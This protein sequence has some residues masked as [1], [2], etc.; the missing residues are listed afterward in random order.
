MY[1]FF[2]TKRYCYFSYFSENI[3]CGY[4]IEVPCCRGASNKYLQCTFSWR[5]KEHIYLATPLN[6]YLENMRNVPV[7]SSYF[8][9]KTYV[10]HMHKKCLGKR[11][12]TGTHNISLRRKKNINTFGVE[13]STLSGA[14][15]AFLAFTV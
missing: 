5:N 4:S 1:I 10:V 14:V 9:M 6:M 7:F 3:C 13:K 12:P 11:F 8:S 2:S 15:T